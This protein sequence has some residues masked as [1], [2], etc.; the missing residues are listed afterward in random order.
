MEEI[1]NSNFSFDLPK[2][3]SNVIKVIGVGGGGSNAINHMFQQGINGVDFVVCNTDAQA[4]QESPV[5]IKI[6]LG[7]TLTEGLG[8]GANPEVG[9]KAAEESMETLQ[10]LLETQTKMIF[11]TA[12]MGG[13][14]G[15]GAAPILARMAKAMDILTVGIVTMPFQFEGKLRLDQAQ[16]GLDKLRAEVDSLIVINNNKLREVYGNLGFKTGFAKADEVLATAARGIAEVITHHYTQNI[17]LKDAKTVLTNSGTAIMGSA[18][19]SG[20]QRAQEAIVK[21]L[22]SPLLNDNKIKGCKNVLL[23]IVSGTEEITIDEIGEINDFI[24]DE[25]GHNANIIM[26]VGEDESLDAAISV[27]VIATGFNADQQH[28]IVNSEAKKII[29]N[30]EE[31]Q[32]MQHDLGDLQN[33]KVVSDSST[34]EMDPL[35]K[36]LFPKAQPEVTHLLIDDTELEEESNPNT[37]EEVIAAEEDPL[38]APQMFSLTDE[39]ASEVSLEEINKI[40][41][42]I[43]A[44]NSNDTQV[45]NDESSAE[46]LSE[47]ALHNLE[48]V[49]EIIAVE[50]EPQ[51]MSPVDEFEQ[52]HEETTNAETVSEDLEEE[53]VVLDFEPPAQAEAFI[54]NDLD[55]AVMEMEVVDEEEIVA[56]PETQITFDFDLPLAATFEEANDVAPEPIDE[57]QAEEPNPVKHDLETVFQDTEEITFSPKATTEV[58]QLKE[59]ETTSEDTP[60]EEQTNHPFDRT[61]QQTV[62]IE[63]EKRKAQLKKFNYVFKANLHKIE[64]L[65]RQP[66]YKRQGIDL[67]A[68]SEEQTGSRISID[69]DSNDDIQLR[70]NNSYLHDNVD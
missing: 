13:G 28:E 5:P 24:Q 39:E 7:A 29:H 18:Q 17:D 68:F 58:Q 16:D 11:I 52:S 43:V 70:S 27:T 45:A 23:L 21:A 69:R 40:D 42:H 2:N 47:E 65:E 22:D 10:A 6:Q 64:E 49:Y 48:V 9:A 61:I 63:N 62:R 3:R 50:Q 25:A 54:I 67:D 31:D 8:A 56:E 37:E 57:N 51:F 4:L 26:G 53:A 41:N 12:G 38:D 66:A 36:P 32:V 20:A 35:D 34:A 14:T 59:E 33:T 44:E 55:E 19:A 1:S 15:T 46:L 30:L 60:A